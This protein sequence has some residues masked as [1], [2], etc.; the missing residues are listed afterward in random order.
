MRIIS[1][2]SAALLFSAM[3]LSACAPQKAHIDY[4][5]ADGIFWPGEPEKPRIQYLW[6]L[7]RVKG[8]EGGSQL[9]GLLAGDVDFDIE[10][11]RNSDLL[12]T[13]Q[14]VFVDSKNT[15]YI[16]DPGTQRV[17][18]INLTNLESH[19]IDTIGKINF[20]SPIGVVAGP[21][22]RIYVSDADLRVV[23]IFS[24][25][26]KFLKAFE[27]DF[28]R[29]TGLALSPS[30]TVYVVDTWA[31]RIYTYDLEGR[32]LGAFGTDGDL[33]GE[34]HYP[35]FIAVDREGFVYVSDTLNFRVQIF[36]PAGKLLNA[37]GLIGD[38]YGT[39][40]KIKGI[41]VDS[42]GHIYVVDSAKDMVQIYDREGRLLLFF[43]TEGGFYGDFRLPS[44][45]YLD[46]SDRIFVADSFNSRLQV[47]QFL[48]G[49]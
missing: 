8:A 46:N 16:A 34:L 13:P 24:P 4:T 41:S 30:G 47:F 3:L 19:I 18:V 25:K 36:S 21:D 49:D 5:M 31:S 15:L 35:T 37:F 14:G 48:G 10:D 26:G 43:G 45:I 38:S 44:G 6:S 28:D 7:Q 33:P 9:V 40:D 39:F 11:P 2:W 22:G 32:R 17:N 42:E 12:L 23:G 1:G 20:V 27:G 29:P